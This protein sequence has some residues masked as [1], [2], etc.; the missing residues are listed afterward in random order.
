MKRH[1]VDSVSLVFA[2]LFSAAVAWWGVAM[3]S[4]DPL[5]V[6][7]AWI[8]AGTLLIIGLVGLMS[9]LR[10][11]RQAE[12]PLTVPPAPQPALDVDPYNDPFLASVSLPR[13][14]GVLDADAIA[15]AYREAGFDDPAPVS[16]PTAI[17]AP[18]AVADRPVSGPGADTAAPAT[19]PTF[20]D[21]VVT[22]GAPSPRDDRPTDAEA[23]TVGIPAKDADTDT[24]LPVAERAVRDG[25]TK[26]L[27]ADRDGGATS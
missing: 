13:V 11:Q 22:P 19:V 23:P 8:G 12:A 25:D 1:P 24:Q 26:Q 14:D 16:S 2:L 21:P 7:A 4:R 17:S 3:I 9:A 15:A 6:P 5:H 20:D 27:P 10:P 18:T